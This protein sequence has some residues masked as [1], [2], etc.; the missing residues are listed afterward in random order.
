[1]GLGDWIMATSQIREINLRTGRIVVVVD[2]MGRARWSEAFENN[3]RVRRSFMGGDERLLNAAGAR[4]YIKQKTDTHWIW[5]RWD[6]KPGELFLSDNEKRYAAQF[7]GCVLV[8]PNVKVPGSNKEWF[9][10]RWQEVVS[11]LPLPWVQCGPP[12]ARKLEGVDFIETSAREAFALL[13]VARLFVGTEG[14]LH[15]AA[16]A[17]ST[18]AIVLWSEF[19]S[20]TYTGYPTQ[21][22]IRKTDHVCGARIPCASC[23]ASMDSISV[24]DVATAVQ[25]ELAK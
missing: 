2:R 23:K 6:I 17:L 14:A 13:S 11:S 10:E 19:I 24:E 25:E 4:P 12:G 16:A 7:T 18:P 5:K 15:H 20:P 21:R 22:N 1:M 9:F 8:E 3:P